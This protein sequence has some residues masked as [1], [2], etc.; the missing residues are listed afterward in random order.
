MNRNEQGRTHPGRDRETEWCRWRS[1]ISIK[2]RIFLVQ[3]MLRLCRAVK[4]VLCGWHQ[5]WQE[6]WRRVELQAG[7]SGDRIYLFVYLNYVRGLMGSFE[8]RW[9]VCFIP[10]GEECCNWLWSRKVSPGGKMDGLDVGRPDSVTLIREQ[11]SDAGSRM[12]PK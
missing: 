2:K 4:M 3:K 8:E 12:G 7:A 5:V 6:E 9:L 11:S 1:I 10:G